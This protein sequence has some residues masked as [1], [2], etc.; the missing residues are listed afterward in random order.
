MEEIHKFFGLVQIK[1]DIVMSLVKIKSHSKS[2]GFMDGYSSKTWS[3]C[4]K[5]HFFRYGKRD[6][7]GIDEKQE[8]ELGN[9]C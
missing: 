2:G 3:L 6:C 1:M 5:D 8:D 4:F 7:D 9:V